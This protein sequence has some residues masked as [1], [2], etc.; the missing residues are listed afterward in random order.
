MSRPAPSSRLAAAS[1]VALVV[2]GAASSCGGGAQEVAKDEAPAAS[3]TSKAPWWLGAKTRITWGVDYQGTR[4]DLLLTL[5]EAASDVRFDWM[6]TPPAAVSGSR[7]LLAADLEGSR[8]QSNFFK[9]GETGPKPGT[10]TIW[11]SRAMLDEVNRTG[12]TSATIDGVAVTLEK[13]ESGL[14]TL[15]IGEK[16]HVLR[17]VRLVSD[18][19]H[20]IYVNDDPAAP[21]IL[22]QHVGFDVWL[23]A[24]EPA[25]AG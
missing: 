6:M 12:T 11:L 15:Q 24:I 1:F 18:K 21:L 5:R 23:K 19:G 17:Q 10:L 20:E 9:D 8:E 14:R 2:L 7:T 22:E 13:K 16:E 4:Y 3:T 25:P